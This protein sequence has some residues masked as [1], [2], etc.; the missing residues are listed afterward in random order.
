LVVAEPEDDDPASPLRAGARRAAEIVAQMVEVAR[1][2]GYEGGV[3]VPRG[4]Q[5]AVVCRRVGEDRALEARRLPPD[6]PL[7]S[8]WVAICT[9]PDHDHE[10]AE[11]FDVVPLLSLVER[12][13]RLFSLLAAPPGTA[14]ALGADGT[15]T[16]GLPDPDVPLA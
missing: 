5:T 3:D 2:C 9:E 11:S 6:E 16:M 10:A 1:R 13:P 7:A 12:V 15:V 4:R 14:V 8:G